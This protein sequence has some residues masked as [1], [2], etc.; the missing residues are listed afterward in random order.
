MRT[1]I[2]C[3]SNNVK[4]ELGKIVKS[5]P[6]SSECR[7]KFFKARLTMLEELYLYYWEFRNVAG[8]SNELFKSIMSSYYST[9]VKL[10]KEKDILDYYERVKAE[11]EKA[12]AKVE[13]TKVEVVETRIS[14][15]EYFMGVAELSAKR[16]ADLST[17]VGAVIVNDDN[18]IVSCGYNGAIYNLDESTIGWDKKDSGEKRYDL[19]VHSEVNAI[20]NAR[21]DIRGCVI[22][23][24]HSPCIE[25]FKFIAQS[26]IKK[27]IY[28]TEFHHYFEEVKNN[29]KLC[30]IGFHKY[31]DVV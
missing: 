25:C 12:K 30:G 29:A 26:G 23:V 7:Y 10:K 16:S 20:L 21:C 18:R 6:K 13:D 11:R 3:I 24:T 28:K 14:W 27:I 1:D 31:G 9:E 19:I 4:E 17:K 15:E 5:C 2:V 22:Y 8:Y